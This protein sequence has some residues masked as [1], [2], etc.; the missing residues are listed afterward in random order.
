[1]KKAIVLLFA[2]PLLFCS[3]VAANAFF[4]MIGKASYLGNIYNLIY[5]GELDGQ[6]LAWGCL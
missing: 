6:G 1:M 4:G 5:E 3:S 2:V